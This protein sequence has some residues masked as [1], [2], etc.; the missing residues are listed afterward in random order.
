VK[1][2]AYHLYSATS[3]MLILQRRCVSQTDGVQQMA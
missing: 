3:R 1:V 2:N